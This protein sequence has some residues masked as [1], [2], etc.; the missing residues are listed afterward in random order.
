[1]MGETERRRG[2]AG[3][4]WEHVLFFTRFLRRPR[5]IGAIVPSSVALARA[6]VEPLGESRD[7]AVVELGPGTGVFTR[8]ILRRLNGRGRYL[9]VDIEPAFV[10][11]LRRRWP[12]LDCVCA[13]AEELPALLAARGVTGVDH[14]VSGLPFATLPA[15]TARRVVDAV[16][17]ALNPGG[18]FT[19]FQYVH[20]YGWPQAR[21]FRRRMSARLGTSPSVRVVVRNVPPAVVL[22]WVRRRRPVRAV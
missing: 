11:R 17:A 18:T 13:S 15:G 19:T 4:D 1:M 20:A 7:A 14:I 21:A 9:G 6:A 2:P 10:D 22:T 5:T 3:P 16:A 12:G 8:E